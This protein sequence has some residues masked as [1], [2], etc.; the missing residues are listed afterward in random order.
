MAYTVRDILDSFDASA[1]RW[2]FIVLDGGK[3]N[4]ADARIT[5][6]RDDERWAV[7]LESLS[8]S[9]ASPGHWGIGTK[10]LR[11]GNCLIGKQDRGAGD[12]LQVTSDGPDT[13]AFLP[14][15]GLGVNP[16][17]SSI[18]IRHAIVAV[19]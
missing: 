15:Y 4:P 9:S 14:P 5:A 16:E 8:F 18:R 11:F 3:E 13:P 2:Q 1:A 17:V 7:V 10:L 12:S 19:D 6:Y